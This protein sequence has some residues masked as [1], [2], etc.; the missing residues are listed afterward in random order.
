MAHVLM[1]C[2]TFAPMLGGSEKMLLDLARGFI[3]TGHNVTVLTPLVRGAEQFDAGE[4]YRIIRS[5]AWNRLFQLGGSRRPLVSRIARFL[6]VPLLF[7]QVLAIKHVD[8][9][10]VGHALPLGNVAAAVKRM[11]PWLKNIVM[12]YGEDVTMYSRGTR[13]RGMLTVALEAADEIT[14]LTSDSAREIDALESG[15]DKKVHVIPPAVNDSEPP[16]PLQ[17]HALRQQL[18]LDGKRVLLTLGRL[19]PRKGIDVTLRAVKILTGEFPDLV[20]LVIGEGSDLPRLQNLA[21]ELGIEQVVRFLGTVQDSRSV[22][23]IADIFCM[24]NRQMSD[25]EREGFGIVFLEAGLAGKPVIAGRS[26]GAPDAVVHEETGL[27]VNPESAEEVAG[28]IRRLLGDQVLAS[29]LGQAG[30]QRA[31]TQ[32]TTE[33]FVSRYLDLLPFS[34]SALTENTDSTAASR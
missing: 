34:P 29:R 17:V 14:C 32:F 25:G 24:P 23:A 18:G 2:D 28:A 27:L 30:R 5:R 13:M 9:L 10:L 16:D 1:L 15:L 12:T 4:S 3:A 19:A 20:Y 33:Q 8:V 31:L 21:G 26:G 6:I 7:R 22:Y 11:R